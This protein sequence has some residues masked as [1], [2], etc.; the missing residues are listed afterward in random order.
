M[1]WKVRHYGAAGILAVEMELAALLAVAQVRG[2]RLAAVLAISDELFHP[3]TPG[4]HVENSSPAAAPP[5]TSPSMSRRQS[6]LRE[7]EAGSRQQAVEMNRCCL[8]PAAYCLLRASDVP[9][10]AAEADGARDLDARLG[11]SA[12]PVPNCCRPSR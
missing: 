9:D 2:V 6:T 11:V 1:G 12:C 8:L 7:P 3:W 10:E 5:R 4:W